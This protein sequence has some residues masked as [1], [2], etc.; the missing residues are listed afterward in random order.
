MVFSF[1]NSIFYQPNPVVKAWAVAGSRLDD[2]CHPEAKPRDL[3]ERFLLSVE[4][5]ISRVRSK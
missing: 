3:R 1:Y 5:R 4:T 2:C